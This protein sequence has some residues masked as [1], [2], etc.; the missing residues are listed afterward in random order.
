LEKEADKMG[1]KAINADKIKSTENVVS[2][3]AKNNRV[4]QRMYGEIC[5]VPEAGPHV[6]DSTTNTIQLMKGKLLRHHSGD[7]FIRFYD[8]H[9]VPHRYF[10][11]GN[12]IGNFQE[13]DKVNFDLN[14]HGRAINLRPIEREYIIPGVQGAGTA[15]ILV[16]VKRTHYGGGAGALF[17][18]GMPS[19]FG[20]DREGV[21]NVQQ[22]VERELGEEIGFDVAGH[23]PV[24]TQEHQQATKTNALHFTTEI[25]TFHSAPDVIPAGFNLAAPTNEM[26]RTFILHL[27]NITANLLDRET[28]M[29]QI[30]ATGGV[31]VPDP[32][33]LTQAQREF[34][35]SATLT[36]MIQVVQRHRA[37]RYTQGLQQAQAG[38]PPTNASIPYMEGYNE[39]NQ[40]LARA[41]SREAPANGNVAY[42]AGYNEYNQGFA[43]AQAGH[44]AVNNHVAYMAG[45]QSY[46]EHIGEAH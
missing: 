24:L 16:G 15:S 2:L 29:Q 39:Y 8:A 5:H 21:E 18:G 43:D 17:A 6:Q 45:R 4:I 26:Q 11:Q 3:T 10:V 22:A 40:G 7:Y 28:M 36:G 34:L 41:R 1:R 38:H 27:D 32:H 44:V 23:H 31:P 14:G 25:S 42:M 9:N 33:H 19:A 20:G 30:C 12:V 37:T 35:D 13:G 46:A